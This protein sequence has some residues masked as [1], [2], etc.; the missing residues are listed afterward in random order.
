MFWVLEKQTCFI[1]S[2]FVPDWFGF[3]KDTINRSIII[4]KTYLV[5]YRLIEATIEVSNYID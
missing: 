4:G 1:H 5:K 3:A 2:A